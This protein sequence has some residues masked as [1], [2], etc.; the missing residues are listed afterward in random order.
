MNQSAGALLKKGTLKCSSKIN[1]D[2]IKLVRVLILIFTQN[3]SNILSK[4][5]SSRALSWYSDLVI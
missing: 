5:I 3:R 2:R 1:K 4:Y